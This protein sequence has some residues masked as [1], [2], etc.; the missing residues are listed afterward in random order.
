VRSFIRFDI[1]DTGVGIP[2]EVQETIFDAFSQ[3]DVSITRKYGGSGLGLTITRKLARLLGGELTLEST[4]KQGSVFTLL[5]SMISSLKQMDKRYES[6]TKHGKDNKMVSSL[7]DKST[8]RRVLVVDDDNDSSKLITLFL[9]KEGLEAT[10]IDNG[11]EALDKVL[12]ES[13]DLILMDIQIPEMDGFQITRFLRESGVE[14]PI[15]A[16]TAQAMK[17]DREK[18]LNAGCNDY[19]SKPITMN[20]LISIVNNYL[21]SEK[22]EVKL[23]V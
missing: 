16:V 10:S 2:P 5:I 7:G 15:I 4:S 22:V 1:E 17:G 14:T 8:Q 11:R 12:S 6:Y 21:T 13:F 20:K 19:L 23:D 9:E 3:A 18:C